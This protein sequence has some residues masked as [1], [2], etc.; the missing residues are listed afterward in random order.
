[1]V[2]VAA[3]TNQNQKVVKHGIYENISFSQLS[4]AP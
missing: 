1:M 3:F 2:E 4:A